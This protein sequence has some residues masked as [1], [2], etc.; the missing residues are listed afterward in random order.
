MHSVAAHPKRTSV[1][2]PVYFRLRGDPMES[3]RT[4]ILLLLVTAFQIACGNSNMTTRRL[5][6]LSVSPAVANPGAGESVQFTATGTFSTQPSPAMVMPS[7]WYESQS[8]GQPSSAGIVSVDQNGLAHCQAGG[9]S[10]VGAMASSGP[11]MPATSTFV[12]GTGQINCP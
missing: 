1:R 2:V 11:D 4:C 7:Q 8:D 12:R 5:Q 9:T 6:T 10:W 3:S